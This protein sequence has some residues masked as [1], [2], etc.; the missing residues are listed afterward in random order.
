MAPP[1]KKDRGAA[2]KPGTRDRRSSSRHSTPVSALTSS[3]PPTPAVPAPLPPTTTTTAAPT[4]PAP[5]ESAHPHTPAAALTSPDPT[6]DALIA[7]TSARASDPPTAKDLHALHDQLRDGVRRVMGRRG[8]V[9]DR[10]MRVLV[11]RRKER[12]AGEREAEVA[13]EAAAMREVERKRERVV[14]RKR[15]RE[16]MEGGGEGRRVMKEG[17]L[18]MVGAHGVARQDGV[19]VHEG[20]CLFFSFPL[21]TRVFWPF[22]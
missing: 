11:Q 12:V 19:G 20:A 4:I 7:A 8:E 22:H 14:G 9:C 21:L 16:A 1:S 10:A 2:S 18:P 13:R 15:S 17:G 6:I 5:K 3:A